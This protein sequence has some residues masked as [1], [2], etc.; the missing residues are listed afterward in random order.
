MQ[1]FEKPLL[2]IVI[3]GG[4][5]WGFEGLTDTQLQELIFGERLGSAIN[6]LVGAAAAVLVYLSYSWLFQGVKSKSKSKK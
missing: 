5:L 2:W 3:L 1:N 4:F 6:L